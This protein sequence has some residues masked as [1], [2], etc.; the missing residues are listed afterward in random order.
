M[1]RVEQRCVGVG[2]LGGQGKEFGRG[3]LAGCLEVFNGF[4]RPYGPVAQQAAG[5]SGSVLTEGVLGHEVYQDA[6]VIAGV[7]SDIAAG[8]GNGSD[9]VDGLI[10][11]EWG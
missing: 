10:A 7:K 8:F 3:G 4:A 6:V 1:R 2:D 5:D 11:V 9:D